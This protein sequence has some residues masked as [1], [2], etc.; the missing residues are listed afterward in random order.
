MQSAASAAASVELPG[1]RSSTSIAQRLADVDLATAAWLCA[2]PCALVT[3]A[4]I[5]LFGPL[6]GDLIAGDPASFVPVADVA[7]RFVPEPTEHARYLLALCGPLL[8]VG[9]LALAPRWLPR[10]PAGVVRVGVP[11]AQALLV[12]AALVCLAVQYGAEHVT[13]D[14]IVESDRHFTIPTLIAAC[15]LAAAVVI[16]VRRFRSEA[17]ALLRDTRARRIGAALGAVLLTVVWLLHVVNSDHTIAMTEK[18]VLWHMGFTLD[19]AFAVLNGRT[20]LVDFTAQYGSLSLYGA[21]LPMAVLGDSMLTYSLIMTATTALALLAIYAVLHRVTRSAIGALLLY[22]PFLATS[23]FQ[24]DGT[25]AN[26]ET[27]GTYFS[28]FPT[29]YAGAFLL[30]WLTA[31]RIDRGGGFA[32]LWLLFA[33]GGLVA[34][35]NQDFGLAALAATVAALVCGAAEANRALLRRL[36]GALAAGVG[37]ALALVAAL[38]LVSAGSLPQ[39]DRALDYARLFGVGGF[40]MQPIPDVIGFHLVVYATFVAAIVLG[41]IRAVQRAPDRLLSGMLVWAGVFGLGAAVYYV[42]RSNANTLVWLF[43]AWTFA[44]ALL[45]VAA[46]RQ[47]AANPQ[48]RPAIATIAVL[49]GFGIAAC[50]L[51]QTPMP[52]TQAER[53]TASFT[54]VN[55]FAPQP[56]PLL[57]PSD[58]AT[59]TFVASLADGPDRFVVREGAPVAILTTNGHRVADA[60]GVVNVSP[61]TGI[62]SLPSVER[63][64]AVVDALREAGGNTVILPNPLPVSYIDVLSAQGFEIVTD[65]GLQPYFPGETRPTSQPWSDGGFVIK[66]V[67]MQN[68]HPRALQ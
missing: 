1:E 42:G 66:M 45:T 65:A 61:Y 24:L 55:E 52:W 35:N 19:E 30:A 33:A 32:G 49:V 16:V 2:L 8:F 40:G 54:P 7:G 64:E 60:Y 67:D 28:T 20:P 9:A 57:P 53:L 38:T 31:R 12:V 41:A 26:R 39:L 56:N 59:R 23:M 6:L 5:V 34:V 21:A 46:V 25:N 3:I 10:V 11:A 43:S 18:E 4:A 13:S 50:S 36:A 44:L 62:Y 22:L 63:V 51:A 27:V 17:A 48:R 15:V 14:G 47:L 37:T 58:P 29:R 68:L